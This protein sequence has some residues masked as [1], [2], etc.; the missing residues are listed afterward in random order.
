[1]N[2]QAIAPL[3]RVAIAKDMISVRTRTASVRAKEAS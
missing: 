3:A 1:M 2:C